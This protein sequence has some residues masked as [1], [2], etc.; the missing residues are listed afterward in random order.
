LTQIVDPASV[1]TR[2]H[3]T[4]MTVMV[5][6][7]DLTDMQPGLVRLMQDELRDD[8]QATD[9]ASI[10]IAVVHALLPGSTRRI[11]ALARCARVLVVLS[12]DSQ[13]SVEAKWSLMAA[14]AADVLDW[15]GSGQIAA[16]I[17][18]RIAR[19]SAIETLIDD[20]YVHGTVVGQS[21]AWRNL[22]RQAVEIA[23]FSEAGLL[24]TGE[25]GTGKEQIARLVHL[26]DRRPR[27]AE[28]VVV[29]CTT[30]SRELSG[31]ELF[32]HERGAF[33][34]AVAPRDGAIA[35]AHHGT[36]FL[37]E[38]GELE[39]PLQ[40]QLLRVIQERS[41]KRVGSNVWQQADFRL[42]CATNRDLELDV[43]ERRFRADLY[44]RIA[45]RTLHLPPLRDRCEDILPLSR[46]F[47]RQGETSLDKPQFD[48]A[49]ER[50][51]LTREYP[52]NVR[53]LRRL[54]LALRARHVGPGAVSLGAL[55]EYERPLSAMIEADDQEAPPNSP[56][57]LVA[58]PSFVNAIQLAITSGICL[59]EIGRAASSVA[60]RIVLEQEGGNLQRAAR[61]L[62][63][64][65][66]ALQ[67]RRTNDKAMRT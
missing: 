34:G 42:I 15:P 45:D 46:H 52:G 41:F 47:W 5:W 44:Y 19:L 65:D 43:R 25:T 9:D 6:F 4:P 62:G 12:P 26:L 40:A 56:S 1:F 31:S 38:I 61:R 66:R 59:K 7:R 29:D 49:L 57:E 32:G 63:V 30:L 8:V 16:R 51:L 54:A 50:F 53:D 17:V 60:I 37:D 18:P 13:L 55:P 22:L 11:H 67:M 35:L 58:D 2:N 23:A 21:G 36:L 24:L 27:K 3:R 28:L 64:T 20:A 39:L 14:G 48:Q 10:G 33:T